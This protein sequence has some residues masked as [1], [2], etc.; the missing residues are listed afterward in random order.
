MESA[1]CNLRIR[2]LRSKLDACRLVRETIA[3]ELQAAGLT[4]GQKTALARRWGK[5]LI[6]S[7]DLQLA[8]DMLEQQEMASSVA[9][10]RRTA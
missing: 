1:I 9:M 8:I 2:I 5:T 10:L 3:D 4:L 6:E 7:R